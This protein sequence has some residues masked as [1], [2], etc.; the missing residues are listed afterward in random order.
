MKFLM[1]LISTKTSKLIYIVLLA[2]ILAISFSLVT[3]PNAFASQVQDTPVA[4]YTYPDN[5]EIVQLQGN[6]EGISL[7][8][9]NEPYVYLD[10]VVFQDSATSFENLVEDTAN[11]YMERGANIDG[12]LQNV[13]GN[14]LFSI[15]Y[16]DNG[17]Y[18]IGWVNIRQITND[19]IVSAY[20]AESSKYEQYNDFS[21]FST[22]TKSSPQELSMNQNLGDQIFQLQTDINNMRYETMM[23]TIDNIDGDNDFEFVH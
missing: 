7:K 2:S 3:S 20:L 21:G 12:I 15:T 18:M 16:T 19:V 13:P 8:V 17:I 11:F 4:I 10:K 22:F 23:N 1:A 14:Y 6:G 9:V 5:W